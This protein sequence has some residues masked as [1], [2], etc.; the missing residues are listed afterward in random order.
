MIS[1]A[2]ISGFIPWLYHEGDMWLSEVTMSC[3]IVKKMESGNA[4]THTT[5]PQNALAIIVKYF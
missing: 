4:L 2:I 3:E 1:D 5:V